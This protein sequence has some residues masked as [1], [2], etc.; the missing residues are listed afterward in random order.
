LSTFKF[1]VAEK[2]NVFKTRPCHD[3]GMTLLAI[4]LVVVGIALFSFGTARL[5]IANGG[6]RAQGEI[7][8]TSDG[9]TYLAP[10]KDASFRFTAKDGTEHT[11]WSPTGT[12]S[13]PSVG[14]TVQVRYDSADPKSARVV[15][16]FTQLLPFFVV[17][18]VLLIGGIV[19]LVL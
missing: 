12:G 11:I 4:V 6:A 1:T 19:L 14:S 17:G 15:P 2:L 9:G 13:G 10:H 8:G 5:M 18:D 7:L 3:D 16:T